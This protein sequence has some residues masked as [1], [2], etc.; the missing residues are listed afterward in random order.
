MANLWAD[1]I[2]TAKG[3]ALLAKLVAGNTL[4]LTRVSCG[5]GVVPA[6]T[7]YNQTDIA[8]KKQDLE[9]MSVTYPEEGKVKL[10]VLLSNDDIT[11]SYRANQVGV[12]ASDPDDG[13]ILFFIAQANQEYGGTVIPTSSEM[14]GYT[15]EWNF[16]FQ[17]GQADSVNVTVDSSGIITQSVADDRYAPISHLSDSVK[18]VGTSERDLW[19]EA[20]GLLS[21]I[22]CGYFVETTL[23]AHLTDEDAHT[24]MLVDGNETEASS[25]EVTLEEHIIDSTAHQNLTVDGNES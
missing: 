12:Y 6:V 9:F 11:Q 19:N 25:D 2:I 3:T 5:S 1:A 7:L 8:D 10:P 22:D 18:H 16:Y 4:D 13:E 24:N 17:Y 21:E 14:P 15:C 23:M 20:A